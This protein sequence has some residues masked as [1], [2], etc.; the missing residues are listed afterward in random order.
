SAALLRTRITLCSITS[1]PRAQQILQA[2]C[3][4]IPE[5]AIVLCSGNESQRKL[6]CFLWIF[7]HVMLHRG[8]SSAVKIFLC[9]LAL[10]WRSPSTMT[11]VCWGWRHGV[12]E[13][14]LDCSFDVGT[15]RCRGNETRF[16]LCASAEKRVEQFETRF[17]HLEYAMA[18]CHL[19]ERLLLPRR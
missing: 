5:R 6:P 1:S 14:P 13:S 16:C 12:L 15:L 4:D 8:V 3:R 19:A 2:P 18:S 11:M 10:P 7:T 17:T 9:L